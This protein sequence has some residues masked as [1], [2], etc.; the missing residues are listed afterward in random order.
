MRWLSRLGFVACAGL[1]AG[2]LL[3]GCARKTDTAWPD[4]PGPKVLTSFP[5]IQCFA[6]NVAGDDAT[7]KVILTSEGAHHHGDP[8]TNHLKLAAHADVLFYNG[9]SLDNTI[10][11]KVRSASGN[12]KLA[13]I[14]LGDALDQKALL[15]GEC[16][17]EGGHK[18]GEEHDHGT[19]P[20]VWLS[21][22]HAKTMVGVIRDELKRLD[23]AH[24]A[25]YDSRAAAYVA[26]LDQLE[27]DGLALL[28]D[29][30]DKKILTHHDALQ[31]FS[32]AFG[33]K[34]IDFIQTADVE[35]GSK[36]L[37]KIIKQA[38]KYG[39]RV[40]AVEPQFNRNT[41]AA[42]ILAALKKEGIDAV[43]AEVDTLEAADE[44]DITPDFYERKMRTNLENLAKALQ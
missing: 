18:E 41:A 11:S 23:P 17:H 42:V 26:K 39:V 36:D 37:E 5:P 25:G 24:A 1:A 43:F 29:K 33:L 32:Q 8:S 2:V 19:D 12:P 4:K 31:Y 22:K 38:K 28:K 13:L 27:Q 35:P 10:A 34:L 30:A 21:P 6:L 7:V 15:E 16:H 14:A 20:H 3:G 9:L 40:I 44:A